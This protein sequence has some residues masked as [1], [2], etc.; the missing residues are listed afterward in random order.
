MAVLLAYVPMAVGLSKG[1]RVCEHHE[2]SSEWFTET[3]LDLYP[4]HIRSLL[5]RVAGDSDPLA[6]SVEASIDAW[7]MGAACV[8][9]PPAAGEVLG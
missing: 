8:P 7:G 3:V 2:I 6:R 9:R 5:E 1:L 4:F